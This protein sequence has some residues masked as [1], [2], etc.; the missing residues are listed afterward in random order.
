[1]NDLSVNS[2]SPGGIWPPPPDG[3]ARKRLYFLDAH[4]TMNLAGISG[5]SGNCVEPS[6]FKFQAE[7]DS[8]W[9]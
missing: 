1:M 9:G 2:F 6:T 5:F 3:L 4:I 8:F 7:A